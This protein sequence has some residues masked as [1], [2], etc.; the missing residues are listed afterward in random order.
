[1]LIKRSISSRRAS[2]RLQL[3]LFAEREH[4]GLMVNEN[5]KN[6][7]NAIRY[8]SA[9]HILEACSGCAALYYDLRRVQDGSLVPEFSARSAVMAA[10]AN[11][12]ARVLDRSCISNRLCSTVEKTCASNRIRFAHQCGAGTMHR[13]KGNP[14]HQAWMDCRSFRASRISGKI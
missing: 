11:S 10:A 1:M 3:L 9:D 13:R 8:G 2:V 5:R 6:V 14:P 4:L 12:A 7:F